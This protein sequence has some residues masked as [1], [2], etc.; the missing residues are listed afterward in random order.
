MEITSAQS[1]GMNV[2]LPNAKD[3]EGDPVEMPIPEQFVT[4]LVGGKLHTEP[5]QHSAG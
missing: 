3:P 5:V 1:C 2:V 4:R